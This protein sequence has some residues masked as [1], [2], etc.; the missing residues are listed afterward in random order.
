VA[1]IS[2]PR[3]IGLIGRVAARQAGQNRLVRA[4]WHAIRTTASHF[5]RVLHLLFLQITGV[6]F[7]FFAAAGATAAWKQYQSWHA[8]RVGPGKMYLAIVFA[9]VFAWFG[10]SSFWRASHRASGRS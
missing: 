8:G 6:F 7:I 2:T 1:G 10:V 9:A 3:K 5:G 4:G